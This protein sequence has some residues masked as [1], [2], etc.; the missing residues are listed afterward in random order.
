MKI[1]ILSLVL[2]LSAITISMSFTNVDDR[3]TDWLAWG[4]YGRESKLYIK[5]CEY[6]SGGSG[7]YKFKNSND[8]AVR[9][10]FEL[11]FN[12]GKTSTGSTNIKA[13]HETNGSSCYSCAD[14][15]SGVKEWSLKK[16]AFEGED[17]YW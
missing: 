6:E 2:A 12:N 8:K 13:Y 1:K 10:S 16:I 5:I 11:I 3:C 4:N 7:Y 9:I 14:K 17:G 15:N